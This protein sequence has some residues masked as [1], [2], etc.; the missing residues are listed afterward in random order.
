MWVR[1]ESRL[2]GSEREER[3]SA[4]RPPWS[5]PAP[6][7]RTRKNVCYPKTPASITHGQ[8]WR[9]FDK[10]WVATYT[11]TCR[12]KKSKVGLIPHLGRGNMLCYATVITIQIGNIAAQWRCCHGMS[13]LW[14]KYRMYLQAYSPNIFNGQHYPLNVIVHAA[15][16]H[17]ND[18]ATSHCI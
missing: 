13:H 2:H 11:T 1:T 12:A 6:S 3:I 14:A 17:N 4:P 18:R 10:V 15:V 9:E 16:T 8:E 7:V 5:K